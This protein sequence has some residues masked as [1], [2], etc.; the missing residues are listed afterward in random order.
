MADYT[1]TAEPD[2]VAIGVSADGVSYV[3][4]GGGGFRTSNSPFEV[5]MVGISIYYVNECNPNA[6]LSLC[7]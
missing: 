2:A 6:E 4:Q 3:L 5:V 1:L 7:L